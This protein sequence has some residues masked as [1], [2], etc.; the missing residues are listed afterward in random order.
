MKRKFY[1]AKTQWSDITHS[2]CESV[3]VMHGVCSNTDNENDIDDGGNDTVDSEEDIDNGN[4]D[5]IGAVY[6]DRC[7]EDSVCA[8][9]DLG[10]DVSRCAAGDVTIIVGSLTPGE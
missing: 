1:S 2:R 4:G 3:S 9:T 6:G 7:H 8:S 10:S 5:M